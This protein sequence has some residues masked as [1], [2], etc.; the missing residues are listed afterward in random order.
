ML[1]KERKVGVMMATISILFFL[2]Y[3]PTFL[4]HAVDPNAHI[5]K[6]TASIVCYLM[7]WS[8]GILDPVTY[9][10]CQKNYRDEIKEILRLVYACE[11]PFKPSSDDMI[12]N[13]SFHKINIKA[14]GSITLDTIK[15]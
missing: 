6:T 5:T 10:I 11:N 3:C 15:E 9:I 13:P 8:I 4:L 14:N 7:N 1:E 12:L 2:V